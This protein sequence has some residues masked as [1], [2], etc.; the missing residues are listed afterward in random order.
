MAEDLKKLVDDDVLPANPDVLKAISADK[1]G[2]L[3]EQVKQRHADFKKQAV[4]MPDA[5]PEGQAAQKE[6]PAPPGLF[7]KK[8]NPQPLPDQD[9]ALEKL[10]KQDKLP[11]IPKVLDAIKSGD[12]KLD[13]VMA[14][15]KEFRAK[16]PI[17]SASPNGVTNNPE[18][19][20]ATAVDP[21]TIRSLGE[22]ALKIAKFSMNTILPGTFS[23]ID[24]VMQPGGPSLASAGRAMTG[25]GD[26]PIAKSMEYRARSAIS[27]ATF[28]VLPNEMEPPSDDDRIAGYVA[29]F[30][31]A[32]ITGSIVGKVFS[33]IPAISKLEKGAEGLR[34]SSKLFKNAK[35]AADALG[36]TEKALAASKAAS[37]TLWGARA[38]DV[39]KVATESAATGLVTGSAKALIAGKDFVD[40]VSDTLAESALFTAFGV[41]LYPVMEVAG[42]LF[43]RKQSKGF[44]TQLKNTVARK[45]VQ[46]LA[47]MAEQGAL[48]Q[49]KNH[50][51]TEPT[52]AREYMV[53]QALDKLRVTEP[54]VGVKAAILAQ[55]ELLLEVSKGN[56]QGAAQKLFGTGG[57]LESLLQLNPTLKSLY[58]TG[59]Y[60]KA[61]E[62]A[63]G[64]INDVIVK[65]PAASDMVL[66]PFTQNKDTINAIY[67]NRLIDTVKN[68]ER[69]PNLRSNILNYLDNPTEQN[70]FLISGKSKQAPRGFLE[71]T[72][73][74]EFRDARLKPQEIDQIV[75][76]LF[77]KS[78][79][80]IANAGNA[81]PFKASYAGEKI[82]R[83]D[84]I[85]RSAITF[86]QELNRSF[87]HA[88]TQNPYVFDDNFVK[89][90]P[91]LMEPVQK[92][93][94]LRQITVERD[95]TLGK[96]REL[97]LAVQDL[98]DQMAQAMDPA[99]KT[100]LAAMIQAAKDKSK[101]LTGVLAQQNRN[102]RGINSELNALSK[103][104]L[105][106]V[107][108]FVGKLYIPRR[109]GDDFSKTLEQRMEVA[110]KVE[111]LRKE[112][113]APDT[114]GADK[115]AILKE[116]RDMQ[117]KYR[118]VVQSR[119]NFMEAFGGR[120]N[121]YFMKEESQLADLMN[122]Y[123]VAGRDFSPSIN[124]AFGLKMGESLRR[125]MAR[126]LGP[127]N[128]IEQ[129][130]DRIK[131]KN[132]AIANRSKM[133]GETIDSLGIF[134]GSKESEILQKLGEGRLTKTDPE[135]LSLS[136][137]SQ[138]RIEDAM[139]IVRD[140]Y[141]NLIDAMNSKMVENHL[142]AIQKRSD[143][144]HHFKE[145][146][147]S[148]PGLFSDYMSG[149]NI[150]D[151]SEAF[152]GKIQRYWK[153]NAISDPNRTSFGAEKMRKG[154]EFT[155][156]AIGGLRKYVAPAL[157]RI[158]YTDMIREIDT[159]R[160]FA[161]PE[162][163]KFL[164]GIKDNYLLRKPDFLNAETTAG[165]A[166]FLN[167][168]RSRI[169]RGAILYNANVLFQQMTS[170][171]LNFATSPVHGV[172]ALGMMFNPAYDDVARMSRNLTTR[173][174]L[175]LD[176]DS[177][178]KLLNKHV[179]EKMGISKDTA[180]SMNMT[181]EKAAKFWQH[182]G[183][184]SLKV[185]DRVAA[186]HAFFTAYSKALSDGATREQAVQVG[187]RWAEMIQ[188]DVT[189][190]SQ[191]K[192]YQSILGKTI[193]QF[194]SFTNNIGA[195]LMNDIP[196]IAMRD[197]AAQATAMLVRGVAGIT[198]ANEMARQM[199][200]PAPFNTT[201]FVP[202]LG[203]YRF[204]VPSTITLPFAAY[205]S[206]MGE[207]QSQAMSKSK[208]KNFAFAAAATGGGQV[209]KIFSGK[210]AREKI[211]GG[212]VKKAKNKGAFEQTKDKVSA[213]IKKKVF[214]K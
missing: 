117:I 22:D 65:N 194:S 124:K 138:K 17:T 11:A 46:E 5:K 53:K 30:A 173:D 4:R 109:A 21:I 48:S 175:H 126:D 178:A 90:N 197:G 72:I 1:T 137:K 28:G 118:T 123:S 139:P 105:K 93:V 120:D 79:D 203:T 111:A 193:F 31:G 146:N 198:F 188:N 171:P 206:V 214:G 116:I 86:N 156:D 174:A 151:I 81:G 70:A 160:H 168:A 170:V 25:M 73:K 155:D 165:T 145:L 195:T 66:A 181:K 24:S 61:I 209:K 172:K 107:D 97:S 13:D 130:V 154:G 133:I 159:A 110:P 34:A 45:D 62:A 148:I 39:T 164:Q 80:D 33:A 108:D 77:K 51:I 161:P 104:A 169:G 96:R 85:L 63:H 16:N 59:Q 76:D 55:P 98:K 132:F 189:R 182:W 88:Y 135:F 43:G 129:L 49:I 190:V 12:V 166:K 41:A 157:E 183:E 199:G 40:G 89:A 9:A 82:T 113:V 158:Y 144:F 213:K 20:K 60:A 87:I 74:G 177:E 119:Q 67:A 19:A 103:D 187:D 208:V 176:V 152:P 2:Q 37:S 56:T 115:K 185:L 14:R 167:I 38:L 7:Q 150:Q 47:G 92:M 191:P 99:E 3:L 10:V 52:N 54:V 114:T 91:E 140:I 27:G 42:G 122:A 128:A 69:Y 26:A 6:S 179:F 100:K 142:P 29:N 84:E 58:E 121:P 44:E 106:E 101:S 207:G 204:G 200:I 68:P 35:I 202:F 134:P 36:E 147:E 149:N 75:G 210:T 212:G 71:K 78:F 57:P 141:D 196:N 32:T 23:L 131:D 95:L 8:S 18:I 180:Q 205:D 15:H 64:A 143:Y 94:A 162:M 102:I 192:F 136:P 125:R 83:T 184:W 163:G 186:K 201:T 50:A 112:M 153:N 211:F 127:N